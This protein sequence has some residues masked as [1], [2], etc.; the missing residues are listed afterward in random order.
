MQIPNKYIF[1]KI[2]LFFNSLIPNLKFI[3]YISYI[4]LSRLNFIQDPGK[5]YFHYF[6]KKYFVGSISN[7]IRADNACIVGKSYLEAED[8]AG[9]CKDRKRG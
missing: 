9:W 1:I 3:F 6:S 4:N 8:R 5:K 2:L 7:R